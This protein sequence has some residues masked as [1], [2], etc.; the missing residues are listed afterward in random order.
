MRVPLSWLREYVEVELAAGELAHRLTMAGVEVGDVIE[1]GSWGDCVVGH[2]LSVGPHPQADRLSLCRVNDGAG[3]L[4]VVCGA[5]NVAAGQ[6][7]CFAR[8]GAVLY[9][10]HSGKHEALKPARIRGVVSNGMI[11]SELELGLGEGHEGIVVL[12]DDAPVG[13]PLDDYLGDTILELELT[14]NRLDC[15]SILGVAHEVAA[16]TG[17]RV[18]AVGTYQGR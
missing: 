10:A 16:L 15:L 18:A 5:P 7:I 4:E 8:V 17:K 3:E 1:I 13:T 9:N 11:C 6:K 2:V 12:S 14:P